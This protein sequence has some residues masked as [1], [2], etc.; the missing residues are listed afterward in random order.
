[1][2]MTGPAEEA[3]S[4]RSHWEGVYAQKGEREVSWFQEVPATSLRLIR[5]TGAG[6]HAR[7][8]D[9]GGGASR[10]VDTLLDAGFERVTV[11]DVAEAALRRARDRLGPRAARVAWIAADVTA[12]APDEALD[13]WHDRAVFHFLVR[14]EDRAAYRAAL[15]RGLRSGGHAIVATF[16]PDGPER[17]SGLPVARYD[18]ESLAVELG[19]ELR[20]VESARE[21]HRT[22]AGR[23]QRFQFSR[24]L[25][26]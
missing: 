4:V 3:T 19:P 25:R 21:D 7:I 9:V 15:L 13:V 22:P 10:L 14:P 2:G 20:L 8:V 16:A 5:S 11:L 26:R 23:V 1:M 17:C 24:F 12:W 6:P 18:P